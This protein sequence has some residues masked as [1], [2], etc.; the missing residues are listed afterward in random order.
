[1]LPATH[2]LVA[3]SKPSNNTVWGDPAFPD[4]SPIPLPAALITAAPRT[5]C[6][7]LNYQSK[8]FAFRG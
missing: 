3:K 8:F 6:L 4:V 2:P 7:N 1:M 5:S